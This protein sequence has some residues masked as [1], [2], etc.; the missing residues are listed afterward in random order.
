M[1]IRPWATYVL[2]NLSKDYE[3]VI[4]TASEKPYA[5]RVIAILDPD[6]R[7][8]KHKLYRSSC[9]YCNPILIKD[10]NV[11]G[12]DLAKTVIVDNT[13]YAFAYQVY[14]SKTVV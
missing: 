9:T 12:R 13:P 5:D 6:K 8:I 10:L 3:I 7:L 1:N 11:L 2:Q 4:F 14:K